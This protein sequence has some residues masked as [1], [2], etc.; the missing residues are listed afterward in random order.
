M[1]KLDYDAATGTEEVFTIT[2][3]ATES[4]NTYNSFESF[5]SSEAADIT[6]S[7]SGKKF[8][9]QCKGDI[10]EAV[11]ASSWV[12]DVNHC[13]KLEAQSGETYTISSDGTRC[14]Y[15]DATDNF[16]II[17]DAQIDGGGNS[18][19]VQPAEWSA[20]GNLTLCRCKLYDTSSYAIKKVYG[21]DLWLENCEIYDHDQ[22]AIEVRAGTTDAYF[23]TLFNINR[24]GDSFQ[25][26]FWRRSG[27]TFTV[28]N[29]AV[30]LDT[31]GGSVGFS[32]SFVVGS[33]YNA[34]TG[35]SSPGSNSVDNITTAAWEDT[36]SPYDL[37]PVSGGALEGEGLTISGITADIDGVSRAEPPSIGCREPA[38]SGTVVPIIM[39]HDHF[40]GGSM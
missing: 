16:I 31:T 20:I 29:N 38:P 7:G 12:M 19:C 24:N 13:I 2:E 1:A 14:V 28:F 6:A 18:F 4:G 8:L 39:Q 10:G 27:G 35:T 32:G 34:A 17:E 15:T 33:D 40:S 37:T 25:N 23:N 3:G 30:D 21:G 5:E 36:V 26:G 22:H 9:L 11:F